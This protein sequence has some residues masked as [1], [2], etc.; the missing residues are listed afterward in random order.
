MLKAY[1]E[2]SLAFMHS[3]RNHITAFLE[4]W[5][6]FRSGG[7]TPPFVAAK[8]EAAMSDLERLLRW[9]QETGEF[10]D[11][12]TR[13]MAIFVRTA[14]DRMFSELGTREDLDLDICTRELVT[15]FDRATCRFPDSP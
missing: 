3:H 12:S 5:S 7:C 13:L 8:I 4:I 9:G 14:I 11:F 15:L 2:S 6:N 10:R 1:I